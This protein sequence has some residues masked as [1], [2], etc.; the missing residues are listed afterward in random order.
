MA[1]GA[2]MKKCVYGKAV[3]AKRYA[4]AGGDLA[5]ANADGIVKTGAVKD[6]STIAA[7]VSF[8]AI[9]D[10]TVW[11]VPNPLGAWADP[12]PNVIP[13]PHA[14]KGEDDGM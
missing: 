6:A 13:S 11:V 2:P 14:G 7:V 9:Y 10:T 4:D 3:G 5:N 1:M 12:N 8:P